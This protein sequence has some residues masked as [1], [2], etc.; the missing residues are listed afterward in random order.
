MN[1]K[2]QTSNKYALVD[3]ATKDIIIKVS[4]V[5]KLAKA[6]GCPVKILTNGLKKKQSVFIFKDKE[7]IVLTPETLPIFLFLEKVEAELD[8]SDEPKLDNVVGSL[9]INSS[10]PIQE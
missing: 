4:S 10:R 2:K 3:K 8:S 9:N 5:A 1:Q 6:I 7:Y